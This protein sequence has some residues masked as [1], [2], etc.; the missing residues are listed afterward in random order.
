MADKTIIINGV[1][2]VHGQGFKESIETET[3]KITCFDEVITQGAQTVAYSLTVDR[4]VYE[5]RDQYVRLRDELQKM[6]ST[7]GKLT[8]R[9]V[10]RYPKE[11]PF[12]IVRNYDGVI[13]DGS[14]Y[15]MKPEE[16]SA[17]NL[18]FSA[19]YMEENIE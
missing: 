11:A 18:K 13:F 4:V 7:P 8:T 5:T 10:V 17:V 9:E 12:T 3:N 19:S 15:E 6:L 2:V 16:Y 14:D 1:T